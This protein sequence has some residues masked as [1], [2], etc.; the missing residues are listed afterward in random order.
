ME[1]YSDENNWSIVISSI[2]SSRT[3]DTGGIKH[4]KT[5][6]YQVVSMITRHTVL[7]SQCETS[8]DNRQITFRFDSMPSLLYKFIGT[9][10][11]NGFACPGIW[12]ILLTVESMTSNRGD[13]KYHIRDMKVLVNT[14]EFNAKRETHGYVPGELELIS[15]IMFLN[16]E[17][18]LQ[19]TIPPSVHS[20]MDNEHLLNQL[21]NEDE[22]IQSGVYVMQSPISSYNQT[23]ALYPYQITCIRMLQMMEIHCTRGRALCNSGNTDKTRIPIGKTNWEIVKTEHNMYRISPIV[24][25]LKPLDSRDVEL[26]LP[27]HINASLNLKGG[28]L[29]NETG[30]GK[31]AIV[32]SF[33]CAERDRLREYKQTASNVQASTLI[34]VPSGLISQWDRELKACVSNNTLNVLFIRKMSDINKLT[35]L[36]ICKADVVVTTM[37]VFQNN[38]YTKILCEQVE[39]MISPLST[40]SLSNSLEY[41]STKYKRCDIQRG[42]LI[43]LLLQMIDKNPAMYT[44]PIMELC[45]WSRVVV[46]EMH[47]Y[48]D[49]PKDKQLL[50]SL[51]CDTFWGITAT[52]DISTH[53]S[54]CDYMELLTRKTS[55]TSEF[56]FTLD[57]EFINTCFVRHDI[58]PSI[59]IQHHVHIVELTDMEKGILVGASYDNLETQVKLCSYFDCFDE[60]TGFQSEL[61]T[62]EDALKTIQER[63]ERK[64]SDNGSQYKL[65]QV[66]LAVENEALTLLEQQ[67]NIHDNERA[68]AETDRI[69]RKISKLNEEQEK[70]TLERNKVSEMLKFCT[71]CV[72]S[73][74][75][76][77]IESSVTDMDH[78]GVEDVDSACP[79][80]FSSFDKRGMRQRVI[81]FCGHSVCNGCLASMWKMSNSTST[82]PCPN[83]RT[84][85]T[86]DDMVCI[87]PKESTVDTTSQL[88]IRYGSKFACV[89]NNA[90]DAIRNNECVLLYAQW[91]NLAKI[92]VLALRECGISTCYFE[93]SAHVRADVIR[94]FQNHEIRV[95]VC[96]G[97][98]S[99]DGLDLY[100]CNNVFFY[101]AIV[102]HPTVV[103]QIERQVVGRL[104]RIGQSRTICVRHFI[105]DVSIE[106]D[107]WTHSRMGTIYN[108]VESHKNGV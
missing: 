12:K 64:L 17:N 75:D 81:L 80:C 46:D 19:S 79:I 34:I 50:C 70:L 71:R 107:L 44:S 27:T 20:I 63:G 43:R 33:I 78:N 45:H 82:L 16:R 83:C 98:Q 106:H 62:I 54:I 74:L 102:K 100:F 51:E 76:L 40:S 55:Q 61:R 23:R 103:I 104:Q 73:A 24:T 99:I 4:S 32:W 18:L 88:S 105:A 6:Q 42:G 96:S 90:W 31:T 39:R 5:T 41:V 47:L 67:L 93:G 37:N 38:N 65:A 56:T 48:L 36:D 22:T 101:H 2:L 95:L 3:Y 94:R 84:L 92:I 26:P 21:L 66:R 25:R 60:N 57:S 30:T 53:A 89:L 77:Q 87:K 91:S 7:L 72:Q 52:P 8:H 13:V 58:P 35:R 9:V 29:C 14:K 86:K 108:I 85:L 1:T 28:I 15:M 59:Q 68:S 69:R 10:K 97:D 11:F 49:V